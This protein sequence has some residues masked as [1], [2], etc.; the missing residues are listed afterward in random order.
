[1][2]LYFS[3]YCT[4]CL[5]CVHDTISRMFHKNLSNIRFLFHSITHLTS[6]IMSPHTI[7]IRDGLRN[8]RKKKDGKMEASAMTGTTAGNKTMGG[9]VAPR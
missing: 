4:F 9:T 1:M 8:A 2:C 5:N 7:Q 6:H 3:P